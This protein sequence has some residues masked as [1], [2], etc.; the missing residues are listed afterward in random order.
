VGEERPG[1][2]VL[3]GYIAGLNKGKAQ[4]LENHSRKNED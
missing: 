3:L 2:A 1:G 4:V